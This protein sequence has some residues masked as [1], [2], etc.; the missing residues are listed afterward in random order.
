MKKYLLLIFLF[1][2]FWFGLANVR[3]EAP[4]DADKDG[5][6]DVLELQFNTDKDNPDSDGDG[7]KDYMEID[8]GYDPMD[9]SDS[10]LDQRVEIDLKK[11]KIYYFVDNYKWKEFKVSTGKK[12]MP[13]PKGEYKIQNKV[14]KAWSKTYGL[15]M[16]YWMGI[17]APGIGIHELPIWPSGYREGEN[18]L[19]VP[20]S[21]GC[22]RLGVKD[23]PYLY[24]RLQVGTTIK[25]Y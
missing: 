12:S 23:A 9:I 6:S 11:Q 8:W 20:V 2:F 25:I 24:S 17:N 14:K 10:K 16:P 5:L 15:W 3:A 4:L 1:S 18:H 22:I 7:F 13:T 19:G 21:H